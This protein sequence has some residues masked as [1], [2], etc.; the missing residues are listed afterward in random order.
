VDSLLEK[1]LHAAAESGRIDCVQLLLEHG[2]DVNQPQAGNGWEWLG[3][4]SR[5]VFTG[6]DQAS[7][8]DLAHEI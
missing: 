7:I 1:P 6:N 8:S 2:A 4:C 3:T 5:V